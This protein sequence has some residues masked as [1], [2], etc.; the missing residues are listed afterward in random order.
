MRGIL[1]IFGVGVCIVLLSVFSFAAN[2]TATFPERGVNPRTAA[3]GEAFVA[4]PDDSTSL[5][6]NPGGLVLA[7]GKDIFLVHNNFWRGNSNEVYLSAN[8]SVL[9]GI[10]GLAGDYVKVESVDQIGLF[11]PSRLG[12]AIGYGK[13]V[14]PGFSVGLSLVMEQ[15]IISESEKENIFLA[16]VGVLGEVSGPLLLGFVVQNIGR[17][18]DTD[19]LPLTIRTGLALRDIPFTLASVG[20]QV[21]GRIRMALDMVKPVGGSSYYCAGTEWWIEELVALRLGYKSNQE[22]G[23]GVT[24]GLGLRVGRLRLDYAHVDQGDS[25]ITHRVSLRW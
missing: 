23:S 15:E 2:L 24:A 1:T 14:L 25:G 6:R 20:R 4:L 5:Y 16:N 7:G 10:L 17:E 21:K 11:L 18:L 8:F 13:R 12:L 22:S 3:L 9:G 19:S